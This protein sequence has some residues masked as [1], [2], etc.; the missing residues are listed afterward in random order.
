M[1]KVIF[2]E[3]LTIAEHHHLGYISPTDVWIWVAGV[4]VLPWLQ[5]HPVIPPL[6][7]TTFVCTTQ[8]GRTGGGG[9]V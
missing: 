5:M 8:G 9:I 4:T 6:Y 2:L 1:P 7:I 3:D